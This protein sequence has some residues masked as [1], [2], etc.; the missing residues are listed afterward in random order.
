MHCVCVIKQLFP[1]DGTH[2]P[3]RLYHIGLFVFR[4]PADQRLGSLDIV[5]ITIPVIPQLLCMRKVRL[6]CAHVH[7]IIGVAWHERIRLATLSIIGSNL[8]HS[9]WRNFYEVH[10]TITSKFGHVSHAIVGDFVDVM[11]RESHTAPVLIPE[12][13][14]TQTDPHFA[15]HAQLMGSIRRILQRFSGDSHICMRTFHV[16]SQQGGRCK[17][18]LALG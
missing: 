15:R 8:F 4:L 6:T 9:V 12:T 18:R 14:L 16:S 7:D 11:R 17:V 10:M 5:E 3:S 2:R 13:D 1:E